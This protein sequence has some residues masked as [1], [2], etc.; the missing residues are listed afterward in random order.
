MEFE[1]YDVVTKLIGDVEPIGDSSADEFRY[2]NLKAMTNLVDR[3]LTDIVRVALQAGRQ[4]ASI[5]RAGKFAEQFLA[6]V[7]DR[8]E[9]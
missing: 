2:R 7:Q 4:E 6:E 9:L 1:V 8:I 3:L 5:R